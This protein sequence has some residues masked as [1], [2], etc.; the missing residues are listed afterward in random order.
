MI[1]LTQNAAV[2][3]VTSQPAAVPLTPGI[4]NDREFVTVGMRGKFISLFHPQ[5]ASLITH[6]KPQILM[7]SP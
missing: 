5:Y 6:Y 2:D 3:K 4:Y 7:S 1:H